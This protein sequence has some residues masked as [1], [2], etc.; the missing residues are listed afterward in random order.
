MDRRHL[1]WLIFGL[2]LLILSL[3]PAPQ[4]QSVE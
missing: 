3:I 1:Q 4:R 2:T